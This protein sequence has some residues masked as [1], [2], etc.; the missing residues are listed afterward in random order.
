MSAAPSNINYT[1][2]SNDRPGYGISIT[3]FFIFFIALLSPLIQGLFEKNKQI[4]EAATDATAMT[5][6]TI[7]FLQRY[8]K[9]TF[10][11]TIISIVLFIIIP[12]ALLLYIALKID[13]QF[14]IGNRLVKACGG[15]K[16]YQ[17]ETGNELV[18]SLI[19]VPSN[20]LVDSS[21]SSIK[22][23]VKYNAFLNLIYLGLALIFIAYICY[24]LVYVRLFVSEEPS[25]KMIPNKMVYIGLFLFIFGYGLYFLSASSTEINKILK[26]Q[27]GVPGIAAKIVA[28]NITTYFLLKS[29]PF[30]ILMGVILYINYCNRN[31][32]QNNT[33]LWILLFAMIVIC[34]VST[35]IKYYYN[36]LYDIINNQYIPLCNPLNNT[37]S[38]YFFDSSTGNYLSSVQSPEL[39]TILY[40]S[41]VDLEPSVTDTP[42]NA[43]TAR[44]SILYQYIMHNN[45]NELAQL[46]NISDFK[47]ADL[48]SIRNAMQTLRSFN[49]IRDTVTKYNRMIYIVLGIFLGI[50]FYLIFNENY[51]HNETQTIIISVFSIVFLLIISCIFGAYSNSLLLI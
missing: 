27:N 8:Y 28:T 42:Q 11:V 44:K 4:L 2:F 15:V 5:G 30:A 9:T 23:L 43:I 24:I 10:L 3:L 50:L 41:I 40:N 31:P 6:S 35:L 45:G 20:S 19:Y 7:G 51:K 1:S 33:F 49:G 16:Y 26:K 22:S 29:L 47:A 17:R 25:F 48:T 37:I 32:K 34:A 38:G 18:S 36:A 12:I 39:Q 46:A 21:D 13:I 14:N